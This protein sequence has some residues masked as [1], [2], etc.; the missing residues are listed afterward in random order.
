MTYF[1]A[2]KKNI[3]NFKLFISVITF[4]IV[5][6]IFVQSADSL[7][8]R[9]QSLQQHTLENALH[10]GTIQYY[11]LEGYYPENLEEL[12][13]SS[14]IRYDKNKFYIDYQPVASNIM[15]DNTVIPR[16]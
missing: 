4:I 8:E 7:S 10:A 13:S 9:N 2:K 16:K 11:A 5:I 6:L 14:N 1:K 15:P 12:L 3:F